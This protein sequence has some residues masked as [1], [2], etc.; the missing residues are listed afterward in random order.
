MKKLIKLSE[1]HYIVVDDSEI[2]ENDWY[3]YPSHKVGA[4]IK[5]FN[6][7]EHFKEEPCITL[8]NLK[9]KKITHSTLPL[10]D[11]PHYAEY[12]MLALSECEE[13]TQ[14]YSIDRIYADYCENY[15]YED[16]LVFGL[17]EDGFKAHQKLVK[18]K[19]FAVEDIEKAVELARKKDEYKFDGK[20]TDYIHTEIEIIQSLLPKTEWRIEIDENN[21][22][23][24]V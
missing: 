3:Y 5:Q 11:K 21:K 18:D 10:S 14:G 7:K 20:P 16:Y 2:K 9:A 22:M 12:G 13:L 1:E 24:L 17:F 6:I 19:L 15:P 8:A 23:K 4:G